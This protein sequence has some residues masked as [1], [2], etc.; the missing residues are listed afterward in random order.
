MSYDLGLEFTILTHVK[1]FELLKNM[2]KMQMEIFSMITNASVFP[3][4]VF[5]DSPKHI[6]SVTL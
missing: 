3:E 4:L 5:F 2:L 6:G 1:L